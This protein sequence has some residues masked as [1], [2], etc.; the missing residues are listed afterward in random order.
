MVPMVPS[1]SVRCATTALLVLATAATALA[2]PRPSSDPADA[3]GFVHV[4]AGAFFMGSGDA[5]GNA[6][7]VHRVTLSRDFEIG[8]YE[9]TQAQWESVMGGNPSHFRG[10][11]RPVEQVSWVDVQTFL[12]IMNMRGDGYTYRLPTEAEW[13][14]SARADTTADYGGTGVLDEMGWY[15]ENSGQE[16]HP[17]GQK[18]PNA[19][20][21]YDMHGNVWEWV[22]DWYGVQYYAESPATDPVGPGAGIA[23]VCRGG[24]WSYSAARSK[25][26]SRAHPTP[27]ARDSFIGFRLVRGRP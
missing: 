18:E 4:A 21:L 5:G 23:R 2:Q 17:V 25:S 19:W 15:S 13:E 6:M 11:L 10:A 9:V 24:G 26:A 16:T 22:H 3:T 8:K 27:S 14:Y 12:Q 20:G 1:F 7:P